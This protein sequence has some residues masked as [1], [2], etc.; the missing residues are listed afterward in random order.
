MWPRRVL[1]LDFVCLAAVVALYREHRG[2][3]LVRAMLLGA[4]VAGN[5][6]QLRDTWR[7]SREPLDRHAT[8]ADFPLPYTH[9]TLDYS[10][11]FELVDWAR[12]MRADVERGKRVILVHNFSSYDENATNPAAVLERLYLTLGHDRFERSVFVFG[13]QTARWNDFPIR[14]LRELKQFADKITEPTD[15][16]GY[17]RTHPWDYPVFGM[18]AAATFKAI[19]QRWDVVWDADRP[20]AHIAGQ[21]HR[22][23]LRRYA[24]S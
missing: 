23:T 8:G 20:L 3:R 15:F 14:P 16:V 10:V 17:Y 12:D 24:A 7:W 18:D 13:A 11:P 6:W 21:I 9:T 19:S 5:A 4:L 2:R 22:F 1:L